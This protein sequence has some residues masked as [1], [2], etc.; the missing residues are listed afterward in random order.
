MSN[1]KRVW[2]NKKTVWEWKK[3]VWLEDWKLQTYDGHWEEAD[4]QLRTYDNSW[5]NLSWTDNLEVYDSQSATEIGTVDDYQWW[6]G[7]VK[8]IN[9]STQSITIEPSGEWYITFNYS[10]ANA[11]YVSADISV[12]YSWEIASAT[13][14][15][16]VSGNWFITVTATGNEGSGTVTVSL[17]EVWESFD[18]AVTVA[19]PVV[20]P[21]VPWEHTIAYYPFVSDTDDHS[22]NENQ[23]T[24]SADTIG[25]HDG[26]IGKEIQGTGEIS[27][28]GQSGIKFMSVWYR[29][30]AFTDDSSNQVL[31]MN[32]YTWDSQ[33]IFVHSTVPSLSNTIT[34]FAAPWRQDPRTT[35][36]QRYGEWHHLAYGY[37]E[38]N[39]QFIVWKDGWDA[40]VIY[41]WAIT[42]YSE[43]DPYFRLCSIAGVTSTENLEISELILEDTCWNNLDVIDYYNATKDNY[44]F[45]AI[46]SLSNIPLT[47]EIPET[48]SVWYTIYYSPVD[49]WR[50][51]SQV[52]ITCE[53]W[54]VAD[55]YIG[56]IDESN[57]SISVN[58][59]GISE[60]TDTV[61][62][63]L[64]GNLAGQTNVTVT[65]FVHIESIWQPSESSV[66]L[67]TGG[68]SSGITIGMS[69]SAVTD[70]SSDVT[71]STDDDSVC[72]VYWANSTTG[73]L[74]IYAQWEWTTQVHYYLNSAP[75]TVYN[76]NVTVTAAE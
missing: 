25:F 18:I 37:D 34:L 4:G 55:A 71:L 31:F 69:P 46:E 13:L 53:T 39:E 41:G 35:S 23:L 60:W 50:I 52:T 61:N 44:P 14:S 36:A 6:D 48:T 54:W 56:N 10:P 8:H 42:H 57:N 72:T 68:E 32:S 27:L 59:A 26:Q 2:S 33:E 62:Y 15:S 12:T 21:F 17:P 20:P 22:G 29:T 24:L 30:N 38:T 74:Q 73:E 63:Y 45:V 43:G 9:Q 28:T 19:T 76:I 40:E 70:A 47:S 58:I 66:S 65:P 64:N 16:Y 7:H 11:I 51:A 75:E 49:A 5:E 3:Q 1:P 67:V